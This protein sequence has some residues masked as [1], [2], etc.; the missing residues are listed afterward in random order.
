MPKLTAALLFSLATLFAPLY[1]QSANPVR[2]GTLNYVEGA[3]TLNGQPLTENAVGSAELRSGQ[4]LE[5]GEGRA[6]LLLTPGDFLRLDNNSA[7]RMISPNLTHT[8]VALLSGRAD[9]EVDQ[10]YKENNISI[11]DNGT[12]TQLLKNGLYEFDSNPYEVRVFN[13]KAAVFPSFN[14]ESNARAIVVKNS[15]ELTLNPGDFGNS[16]HFNKNASEDDLYKWSSLR[17]EYLGEANTDLASEY[18][19][20]GAFDPGWYWDAGLYGYTWLPGD[21]LFW[22]PFGFGFY[23]PVYLFRG[24][25]IYGRY[26]HGYGYV[27]GRPGGGYRGGALSHGGH[28][29]SGGAFHGGGGCHGGGG[30][31]GGGGGHR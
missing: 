10:I 15:H 4:T 5:T 29:M 18:A 31:H 14:G 25:P 8:E 13:G 16:Q 12:R 24:G 2:P 26:G 27:G 23:S 7:V 11:S 17:S 21:G 1:G 9:V 6:E 22:S 19:G 30:F 20:A 28:G 3:A